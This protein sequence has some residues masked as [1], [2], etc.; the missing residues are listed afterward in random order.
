MISKSSSDIA[1]RTAHP[2]RPPPLRFAA[3]G[4]IA[5]MVL[6]IAAQFV[7][8]GRNHTNPSVLAEPAWKS[9][10]TRTLFF[11]ACGDCHSNQ[12][13]WPW[14]S[15]LAPVSWLVQ[16]DVQEGRREFNVSEWGRSKNKADEAA[17]TI[18]KG[19]MPPW[20][21][22]ALHPSAKLSPSERQ[23]F[24]AGLI[25]TFGSETKHEANGAELQPNRRG[26][27]YK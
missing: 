24:I 19:S 8:Y 1:R 13:V 15:N 26:D 21:Y 22:I 6:L 2:Q 17:E 14:Y 12:T 5:I 9:A 23:E 25:A 27:Y 11:R 16:R 7:P 10:Q 18:Q 4:L 3:V 20:F